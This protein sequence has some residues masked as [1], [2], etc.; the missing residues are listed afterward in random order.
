MAVDGA[1][2]TARALGGIIF[3]LR[4]G[5][6][7]RMLPPEMGC[8]SGVMRWRRLRDWQTAGVWVRLH[9]RLLNR[10]GGCG[11]IDRWRASRGCAAAA[12]PPQPQAGVPH[13]AELV[14][15]DQ[16]IERTL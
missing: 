4:S 1:C 16:S 13:Q 15:G 6:P 10:L 7:W 11:R 9:R 14:I 5:I 8:G 3:V 2:R 12:A